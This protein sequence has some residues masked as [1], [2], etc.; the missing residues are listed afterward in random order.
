MYDGRPDAAR[1]CSSV[2]KPEVEPLARK[3]MHD[4]RRVSDERCSAADIRLGMPEAQRERRD[5]P[6]LDVRNEWGEPM[7]AMVRYA[8]A[9]V[10]GVGV[11]G[12]EC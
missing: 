1:E 10:V 5:G 8:D 9:C 11:C 4:V 7:R 6:W 3:R 2:C 12:R